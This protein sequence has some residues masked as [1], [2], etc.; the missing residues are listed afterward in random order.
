MCGIA[1][2]LL[3]PPD[4]KGGGTNKS[5]FAKPH[6]ARD[7][8]LDILARQ[9]Y[10]GYDSA[11]I[12]AA[13]KNQIRRTAVKGRVEHLKNKLHQK[14]L[15]AFAI[16]A[17]GHTRW[18][19]HGAPSEKNAHPIVGGNK[20]A[21]PAA[22]TV[23]IVHN[24]IIENHAL[25]RAQLQKK[26]RRFHTDTDSE[27]I[28][29][30]FAAAKDNIKTKGGD[31][32]LKAI[33]VA[34]KQLHGAFAIAAVCA[35]EDAIVCARRG[36]PLLIGE[37]EG[38]FYVSSDAPAI[39]EKAAR[40]LYLIDGDCAVI[41][42]G[43]VQIIG[44]DGKDAKRQ[45]QKP[46]AK[47]QS[48]NRGNYRHFMKKEMDEQPQ[49][50]AAAMER[51]ARADSLPLGE[52]G[53]GA[54]E[55]FRK[56]RNVGIVACGT[57]YHAAMIARYWIEHLAKVPCRADIA[58]E[59]RYR[60]DPQARGGL[61]VAVS[62]SGE[63]ADTLAAAMA[64]KQNGAQLM[65]VVNETQSS[66]ADTA[67]WVLPMRAGLE[68][69]VASTKAFTAQLTA[70]LL[71]ALALAKAKKTITADG[72]KKML[73]SMRRL[74][75]LLRDALLTEK[76][77]QQWA[78]GIAKSRGVLFVGRR[79]HYPLALEGAL[80]LKEISYLHAEGCAAG[81]LKHGTLALVDDKMPVVALTSGDAKMSANIAEIAA[82]GGNL[83]ILAASP[84]AKSGNIKG[85]GGM[86]SGGVLTTGETFPPKA[87][88][89]R[90]KDDG[91]D[92]LSPLV[93]A[94][95]LQLLAYHTA[96]I[97]GADIDKPRN[98]AKSVTVE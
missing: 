42:K 41:R 85:G 95:P 38:V 22:R 15:P 3:P 84:P 35:G 91:G 45:W 21:A 52:F 46:G 23:A 60:A 72:E 64:A 82:R 66:L 88:I 49:A 87:R 69:G 94:P 90:I 16:A 63:T 20:P 61:T 18:A 25:L 62:Q 9:E 96:L 92:Y 71:L 26:G 79:A 78:R 28:A 97:K 13:A 2:M 12:A 58:S 14:P 76:T 74:P 86:S 81:E 55:I 47:S 32:M 59:Y 68:I 65:A 34:T 29:H 80:K 27:V 57:S 77:M 11:G 53:K 17:I 39:A 43:K 50:A 6:Y 5:H 10:R 70:L 19:T 40:L 31:A 54:A 8:L 56:C 37:S 44:A 36:S 4:A 67:K 93:F 98:L 7:I 89:A 75:A 24:G 83:H 48:A 1:G 51:F 33:Q 73:A 30:L